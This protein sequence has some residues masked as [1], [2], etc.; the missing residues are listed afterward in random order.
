MDT[1]DEKIRDVF[2]LTF[3]WKICQGRLLY[4]IVS[5]TLIDKQ[6]P[7]AAISDLADWAKPI[8]LI[9]VLIL[10]SLILLFCCLGSRTTDCSSQ[11]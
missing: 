4:Y 2:D 11:P 5:A 10:S 7:A 1:S 8:E 3:P 6:I 9:Q